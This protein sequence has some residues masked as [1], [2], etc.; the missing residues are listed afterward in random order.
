MRAQKLR[1]TRVQIEERTSKYEYII[2]PDGTP[3][4]LHMLGAELALDSHYDEYILRIHSF[5][6]LEE[7]DEGPFAVPEVC[8]D[9][10]PAAALRP[11]SLLLAS[12]VPQVRL[13]AE[14]IRAAHSSPCLYLACP[15]TGPLSVTR[16]FSCE[17]ARL[18]TGQPVMPSYRSRWAAL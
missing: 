18:L 12:L 11:M 16:S 6:R 14:C 5:E 4:Q 8:A 2:S 7:S 9:I 15:K 3:L 1:Q 13:C 10:E 17:M